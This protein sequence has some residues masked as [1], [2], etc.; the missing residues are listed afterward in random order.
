MSGVFV[1]RG[2]AATRRQGLPKVRFLCIGTVYQV[3]VNP[4]EMNSI[5][6]DLAGVL[7]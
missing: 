1:G 7:Q 2:G 4:G 5:Q 3:K 6:L